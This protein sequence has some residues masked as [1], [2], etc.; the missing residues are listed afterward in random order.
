MYRLADHNDL[1]RRSAS[2][3][4]LPKEGAVGVFGA[5]E[6]SDNVCTSRVE[7]EVSFEN[8]LKKVIMLR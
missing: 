8:V 5:L 3:A 1:D 4:T 6:D 2:N 7:P